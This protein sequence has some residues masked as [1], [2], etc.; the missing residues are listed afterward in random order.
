[1]NT[2]QSSFLINLNRVLIFALSLTGLLMDG[3]QHS[4]LP[5]TSALIVWLWLPLFTRMEANILTRVGSKR[6]HV[7]LAT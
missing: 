7:V 2:K 1:M 3:F 6:D 4:D 5:C